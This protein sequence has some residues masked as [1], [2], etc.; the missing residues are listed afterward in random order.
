MKTS[1]ASLKERLENWTKWDLAVYHLGACLGFWSEFGAP[2]GEDP[3]HG[4]KGTISASHLGDALSYLLFALSEEKC[5]ERKTQLSVMYRWN[6]NYVGHADL[7][8]TLGDK[9]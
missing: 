2:L 5:L 8:S 1:T 4:T 3:W 6:K 9:Q 7:L